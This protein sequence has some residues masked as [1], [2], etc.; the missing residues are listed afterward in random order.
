MYC[1]YHGNDTWTL[2]DYPDL[3]S[4]DCPDEEDL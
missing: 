4:D 1:K 2:K 3:G